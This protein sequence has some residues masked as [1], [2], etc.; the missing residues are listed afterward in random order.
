VRVSIEELEAIKKE[1]SGPKPVPSQV[2]TAESEQTAADMADTDLTPAPPAPEEKEPVPLE[3]QPKEPRS[4]A[5]TRGEIPSVKATDDTAL[6]KPPPEK[7]EAPVKK[8]PSKVLRVFLY[9][10]MFILYGGLIF[11]LYSYFTQMGLELF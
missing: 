10:I 4:E 3:P 8:K 1:S 6:L 7:P 9:I 5:P 2:E 11:L